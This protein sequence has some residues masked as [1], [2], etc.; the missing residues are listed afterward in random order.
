MASIT[1]NKEEFV[2]RCEEVYQRN[3]AHLEKNY[4]GSIVA[5]HEGGIAGIG[6][7]T[8]EAYEEAKEKHPDKVF[9][10]RRIGKFSAAAYVF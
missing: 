7:S 2:K 10:F 5:I 3:K 8:K 4:N 1:V 6:E 9:Y